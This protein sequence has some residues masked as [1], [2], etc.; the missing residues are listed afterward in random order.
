MNN[1]L[2]KI[3]FCTPEL[4]FWPEDG[5][6]SIERYGKKFEH[7][8]KTRKFQKAGGL[9]DMTA[10]LAVALKQKGVNIGIPLPHIRVSAEPELADLIDREVEKLDQAGISHWK[11]NL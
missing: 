4:T 8:P 7:F 1:A 10:T 5:S 9:A 6:V 3:L 11:H 2:R